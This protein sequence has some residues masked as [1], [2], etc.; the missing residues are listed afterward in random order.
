[1]AFKETINFKIDTKNV[2]KNKTG[3][4]ACVCVEMGKGQIKAVRLVGDSEMH[5]C[6]KLNQME[7]REKIVFHFFL[8]E[9]RNHN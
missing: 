4:L 8:I 5:L 7:N 2:H 3:C 6:D 1:M 9:N